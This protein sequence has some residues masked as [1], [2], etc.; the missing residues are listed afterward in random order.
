MTAR[1]TPADRTGALAEAL[2]A[3]RDLMGEGPLD[4]VEYRVTR[5]GTVEIKAKRAGAQAVRGFK[6]RP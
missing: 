4:E 1:P 6:V 5:G 3:I 2:D